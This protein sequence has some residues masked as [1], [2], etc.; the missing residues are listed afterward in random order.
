MSKP[1]LRFITSREPTG[2]KGGTPFHVAHYDGLVT[3]WCEDDYRAYTQ[4]NFVFIY[5]IQTSDY[6]TAASSIYVKVIQGFE[7][8][9]VCLILSQA[10]VKIATNSCY[11]AK[12][13]CSSQAS[14]SSIRNSVH[15]FL[16]LRNDNN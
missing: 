3:S 12:I 14:V 9:D 13:S 16:K 8:S 10:A 4:N 11:L 6:F 2:K 7:L 5:Y 15:L 1:F